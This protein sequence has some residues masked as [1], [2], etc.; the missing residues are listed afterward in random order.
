MEASDGSVYW[1]LA[2]NLG[3]V[4]DI[5]EYDS[6]TGQTSVVN[7]IEYDAF[8]NITG[9][10]ASPGM[11]YAL[12]RYLYSYTG[13]EWDADAEMYA[14]RA[15][16]YDP[17]VGRFIGEDPIGFAAGD[18][19]VSRY[20]GN[21]VTYG[22]DP[23]GLAPWI[24][25]NHEAAYF[26]DTPD[27]TLPKPAPTRTRAQWEEEANNTN[28]AM[29][30]SAP[31][32][33]LSYW[34]GVGEVFIGYKNAAVGTVKGLWFMVTHPIQT[35]KGIGTAIRHPIRT[36]KAIYRD[37]CEKSGS[38]RGQGELV[39]DVLIGVATG[40][41]VKTVSKTATLAKVTSKAK[42]KPVVR[43]TGTAPRGM[44][45]EGIAGE[46][47]D[48]ARFARM[49]QAFERSGGVI[50]QSADA[51]AY[52]RLRQAE[53]LTF[54]AKTGLLP[55]RPTT[56]AVFDEFIHT[57]QH[58]TGR[59]SQAVDPF[60]TCEAIRRMEIEAAERLIRNRKPC[61]LPNAQTRQTIDR[62]RQLRNQ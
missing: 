15:R 22:V 60:G 7:H 30:F 57:A 13:R 41:T 40:G 4:R 11:D 26:D 44:A 25:P 58:R 42:A 59:F 43:A 52:L 32:P 46:A 35:V 21:G 56:T 48:P 5:V 51:Q 10:S 31:Q 24:G 19:N 8:G 1:A 49:K 61:G 6:G 45:S 55:E 12:E 2:D 9:E 29:A 3:S 28:E 34:E 37:A 50:D 18:T 14:Y 38:L 54:D 17:V 53:G 23:S 47:I 62:L 27:W 33:P 39:G 16:W 20:V 36:G